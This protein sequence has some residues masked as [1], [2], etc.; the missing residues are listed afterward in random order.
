MIPKKC[1]SER[2]SVLLLALGWMVILAAI[3]GTTLLIIQSKHRQAFQVASWQDALIAAESGVDLAVN[4]L[5]KTLADPTTAWL[6]WNR[7][8]GSSGALTSG[9]AYLS[10][11]VLLRT[12]EGGQRSWAEVQ[13]D[14]PAY[15]RDTSGEQ[16]YRVRST[17]Y[18][19]I[20]GGSVATGEKQDIAL[21]KLSFR[22]DRRT[23][24]PV[25]SPRASRLIEAIIKP[26]GTFRL[27]LL[28]ADTIDMNNLNIVVDSYDSR[29]PA[30][31][32]N[33]QYDVAK[34]QQNGDIATNG[35]AI[36]AG[37]AHIYGSASTNAGSVLNAANVTGEIRDD[38]YQELFSVQMPV[39]TPSP[40]TPASVTGSTII[41]ASGGT[42][43][44][45]VLSTINLGGRNTLRI[46][47]SSDG[48]ERFCTVLVNG[49]INLSGQSQISVD[50][51]VYVRIFVV[52]DARLTGQGVVNPNSPLHL[53]LYG[54]ARADGAAPGEMT[55]S[56][57]GGFTGSV[58]APN[59]NISMVGGGSTDS[60]FGAFVGKTVRMTGVQSVHYDE[61]LG[62]GG[63]V[64]DYRV[65]SWFEDAA[66]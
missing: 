62:D 27:A 5:R 53:Q 15:L 34:R 64:S 8:G 7:S 59:Y 33:G 41:D 18:A 6:G 54:V 45:V 31:S 46:R 14:A 29:N 2:A 38:F 60:I 40:G 21:R 16:W 19:E 26:V 3:A 42:P 35:T 1:V 39:M 48:S 10:S 61:A 23:G 4:E 22:T 9:S 56:G 36:D 20:P 28:S 25:S 63:L 11:T 17:G 51:G 37:N 30:K 32:T 58:Y 55:I 57:N 65:V 12:T 44:Q 52:G 13:V 66:R 50:P 43:T 47:G 24:A 49:D